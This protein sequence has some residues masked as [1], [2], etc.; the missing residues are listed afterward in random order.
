MNKNWLSS[1]VN[2]EL[3]AED[4]TSKH[5]G[6]GNLIA[7]ATAEQLGAF[8]QAVATLKPENLEKI[9]VSETYEIAAEI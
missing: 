4:G 8:A 9:T 3:I 5:V 1:R 7:E 2:L 6:Y